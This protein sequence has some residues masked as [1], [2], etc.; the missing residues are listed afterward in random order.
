MGCRLTTTLT[1]PDADIHF[2][3]NLFDKAVTSPPCPPL[4][5]PSEIIKLKYKASDGDVF[6]TLKLQVMEDKL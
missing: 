1:V 4:T 2:L 5:L 3:Q 6:M